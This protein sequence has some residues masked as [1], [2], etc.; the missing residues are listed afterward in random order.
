MSRPGSK[1]TR[2]DRLNRQRTQ[3]ERRP[4][5]ETRTKRVGQVLLAPRQIMA[6]AGDLA[7]LG[8][9]YEATERLFS[10]ESGTSE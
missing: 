9:A 3:Q 7:Y 1:A 2:S 8:T 6:E 10:A 5:A 4:I